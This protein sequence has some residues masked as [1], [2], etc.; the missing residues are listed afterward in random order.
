MKTTIKTIEAKTY[1]GKVTGHSVT[2]DN[3]VTGYLNDK[4]SSSELK[5]GETVDYVLEV[6]KNKQGKDYNLLTLNRVSPSTPS[7]KVAENAPQEVKTPSKPSSL[8]I[9]AVTIFKEKCANNRKAMELIME[10]VLADKTT[11]DQITEKFK[12][13]CNDLNDGVDDLCK[14]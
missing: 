11:F 12:V 4:G 3:G 9:D 7:E 1:Q 6:K 8:T 5:Q 13:V 14:E 2:L 10:Y